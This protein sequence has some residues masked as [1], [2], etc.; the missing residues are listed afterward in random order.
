MADLTFLTRPTFWVLVMT[1]TIA[2]Q[3]D[4]VRAKLQKGSLTEA[5]RIEIKTTLSQVTKQTDFLAKLRLPSDHPAGKDAAEQQLVESQTNKLPSVD[6][7]KIV[8]LSA[9]EEIEPK[10]GYETPGTHT[11]YPFLSQTTV[12]G[13]DAEEL[14]LLWRRLSFRSAVGL[15]HSPPYA[16]QFSSAGKVLLETSVCWHCENFYIGGPDGK[17]KM[18]GFIGEHKAGQNLLNKL[19]KILPNPWLE[20]VL[21]G[22]N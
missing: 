18:Y 16:L 1:A 12:S 5:E 8:A 14:A 22:G 13:S 4:T 11:S 19:R 2:H 17:P 10:R 6:Q 3:A 20:K 21:A 7:V 15:C 9:R